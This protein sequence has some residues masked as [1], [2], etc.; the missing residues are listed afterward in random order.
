MTL[1][2]HLSYELTIKERARGRAV[3]F[4]LRNSTCRKQLY[5]TIARNLIIIRIFSAHLQV[6]H[7]AQ[8]L[9]KIRANDMAGAN[10]TRRLAGLYPTKGRPINSYTR[11]AH[12]EC[13]T[14]IHEVTIVAH[15]LI[16]LFSSI[17]SPSFAYLFFYWAQH[18]G[19]IARMAG[20]L[21]DP[22]AA[23]AGRNSTTSAA[24][25][26][27]NVHHFGLSMYRTHL[28]PYCKLTAVARSGLTTRVTTDIPV[29]IHHSLL[30]VH[31]T[32]RCLLGAVGGKTRSFRAL[33]VD[34][35]LGVQVHH[36]LFCV[37]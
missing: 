11:P 25:P 5:D 27:A 4:I 12:F 29:D 21:G 26:Y 16:L 32:V 3:N 6:R 24:P 34:A 2:G 10:L 31:G 19:D 23:V 14:P 30:F 35:N 13:C 9:D 8:L 37:S 15:P 33:W 36:V 18:R 7:H 28:R 22:L 17:R 20:S 1:F